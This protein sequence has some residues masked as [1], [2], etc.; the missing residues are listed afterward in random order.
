VGRGSLEPPQI[1]EVG[2][3]RANK[4]TGTVY[5]VPK[6]YR[7]ATTASIDNPRERCRM[8]LVESPKATK[9]FCTLAH[10]KGAK[11][12]GAGSFILGSTVG[13]RV[14]R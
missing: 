14:F 7:R 11:G 2:K 3:K 8:G 10:E 9:K 4:S 5:A 12:E 6:T 13:E 1:R